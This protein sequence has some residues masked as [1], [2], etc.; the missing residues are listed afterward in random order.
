MTT[1][2]VVLYARV[3]YD[4][5]ARGSDS[6]GGQLRRLREWAAGEGWKA[7]GEYVDEDWSG[8]QLARPSLNRLRERVREGGVAFVLTTRRDRLVRS[9]YRRRDLDQEF[10][11]HGTAARAMND[12]GTDGPFG[13]FMDGQLDAFA[14]LER[15]VIAERMHTGRREKALKGRPLGHTLPGYGYRYTPDREGFEVDEEQMRAVRLI[16]HLASVRRVPLH[17]LAKE[18]DR[19]GVPSPPSR[20]RPEGGTRWSRRSIRAMILDDKYKPHTAAELRALRHPASG[21]EPEEGQTYGVLWWNRTRTEHTRIPDDTRPKGY[22]THVATMKN[23]PEEHIAIPI[24][25]AGIPAGVVAAAREAIEHNAPQSKAGDKTWQLSGHL[26]CA[27]CSNRMVPNSVRRRN[28]PQFWYRCPTRQHNGTNA[29]KH[30]THHRAG[31]LEEAVW[32]AVLGLV[33]DPHRLLHQYEEH[34]ERRDR[35]EREAY[36]DPDR[37]VRDLEDRLEKLE[38]RRSGYLDLAADGDM[39]RADLRAKLAEADARRQEL[40]TAL[41]EAQGRQEARRSPRINMAH[42][43]SVLLQLNRNDLTM[44]SPEDR[45][46]LYAALRLRADIDREAHVV[47]SGVFDPEVHLPSLL[48]DGSD[49]LSPRPQVPEEGRFVVE[50]DP[51]LSCTSRTRPAP[52]SRRR[53]PLW[54]RRPC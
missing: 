28:P 36:G 50:T 15:E 18:L 37:E 4:E 47:L 6:T 46:R 20:T 35:E 21:W 26:H 16:F 53:R 12:S 33:S 9:G 13:R 40:E 10:A 31:E 27:H 54:R 5:R 43:N 29:C 11:E 48:E 25:D 45:R 38:R 23:P 7:V 51:S 52:P 41:R 24:P 44:A 22:R 32:R 3:S 30:E 14:E 42:L 19:R 49:W 1:A 2:K 8:K 34:L 17:A 39:S